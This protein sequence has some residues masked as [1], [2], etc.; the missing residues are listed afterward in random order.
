M[1]SAASIHPEI[2]IRA[3]GNAAIGFGHLMRALAFA[4]HAK[5]LTSVQLII[6]N[7]DRIAQDACKFYGISLFD[8]SNIQVED[9][10]TFVGKMAGADH[11]VFLDGYQFSEAYQRDI[12]K[13]GCFLV[14]MDDHHDRLFVADCVIN[15]AELLDPQLVKR[16]PNTRLVYG[17]K[18]ALIRPE[19]SIGTENP[20]RLNQAF[21]C[22]GGGAETLPLIE[23]TLHALLI[24][25]LDFQQVL[26]V[27]NEK[28]IPEVQQLYE[29]KFSKLPLKLLCNLSAIDI[30]QL[31]RQS[32]IGICSS[33]TVSLE[34]RAVN[35]PIVAGYFVENQKG[36]YKSL[37]KNNEIP[38]LGNLQEISVELLSGAIIQVVNHSN[39]N[40]ESVLNP[41]KIT[42]NYK[43][44][45][46]SWFVEMQFSMR[47]AVSED[48]DLYFNWANNEDVRQNAVSSD[49]IIF[50]NH[51]R[52]FSSRINSQTTKLYVGLW[53]GTPVGQ[54]RF[55]LHDN[56][57]EI[58][59]SVDP[60]Y[61]NMGLGELL[62]RKGMCELLNEIQTDSTIVGLVKH[63]NIPSAEVFK[64]MHFKEGNSELRSGIELRSFT[65]SLSRQ[66]LYL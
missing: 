23:K 56:T 29:S 24:S 15:V 10:A 53:K 26:I 62:I 3:D 60:K 13:S 18:Y 28:L 44:L 20:I 30:A 17:L 16:I 50:D 6:R 41:T 4:S 9:E 61:R 5:Q 36:I 7:P 12:K 47:K 19:F 46:E 37:L 33:S 25:N 55:D 39:P 31:M 51:Q 64:K 38:E 1:I 11:I 21:V 40:A 22:F 43:R 52:W 45:I 59:Y 32:K 34:A 58:D 57:W 2:F 48:V 63:Q 35:L 14:C 42:H 8:I 66:L 65:Y 54:V 49:P 27:L